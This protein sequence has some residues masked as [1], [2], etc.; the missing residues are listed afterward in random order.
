MGCAVMLRT[1]SQKL[2]ATTRTKMAG[3]NTSIATKSQVVAGCGLAG[4]P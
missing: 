1:V 4:L 3:R 2:D